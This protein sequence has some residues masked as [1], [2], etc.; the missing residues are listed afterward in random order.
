MNGMVSC[1]NCT[2]HNSLDSTFC[3]KCGATL[4]DDEI[5]QA[6]EKLE[7]VVA[8]GF[9]VFNSGRV[10]EAIQIAET[11]VRANPLSTSAL[12]LKAMCHER[13]GQ[14]SEALECHERVLEIDPDSMIDKIKVNDL[15]NLLVARSS[16]APVPDRKMAIVG[17]VAAFVLVASIGV[18]IAKS[19][20]RGSEKIAAN[21][22][23]S[24]VDS[25]KGSRF[26]SPANPPGAQTPNAKPSDSQPGTS[27]PQ[28]NVQPNTA[29]SSRDSSSPALATN[30]GGSDIPLPKL[31]ARKEL[32]DP[33]GYEPIKIGIR[34][35]QLT[36]S[37]GSSTTQGS[38]RP[39]VTGP[40]KDDP[41]P[42][43]SRGNE[44]PP[45]PKEAP[46]IM[47]ITV[48]S[49]KGA[50]N[51]QGGDP[52]TKANGVEALLR[53]ARSQYQLGNYSAAA[54]SF[55]RALRSG[56]DPTSGNQRLAQCYEKLGRN[57]EAIAAYNRA[58]SSLESDLGAGRGDKDRLNAALDSCKQAVKV[59]GG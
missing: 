22:P 36:K 54:T 39:P 6:K 11:A 53:T 31:D 20:S 23:A 45:T 56:A 51:H 3:K 1:K 41:E 9:K 47:E 59:L 4:P 42:S 44:P 33:A 21:I 48:V 26:E 30:R 2:A 46:G 58:I 34:P 55:E 13:F 29:N 10:D 15:R 18:V 25:P 57:S 12:S 32:P 35:D 37:G 17:A 7:A 49:G 24:S 19:G 40:E 8:D 27:P 38:A 43:P 16:I 5:Q 14:I 28:T 50:P 52:A